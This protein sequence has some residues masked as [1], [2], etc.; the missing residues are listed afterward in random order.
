MGDEMRREVHIHVPHRDDL[1]GII[2]TTFDLDVG[3]GSIPGQV[4]LA[5]DKSLDEGIIVRVEYPVEIDAVSAKVRLESAEH[6]D[7]GRRCRP[8]KPHHNS[9]LWAKLFFV[10][11]RRYEQDRAIRSI[12]QIEKINAPRTGPGA[13]RMVQ[14]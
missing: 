14:S 5:F 3:Q 2:E 8:T 13:S 9:L 10:K 6:T 11:A 4:D 7:V 1:A 12:S